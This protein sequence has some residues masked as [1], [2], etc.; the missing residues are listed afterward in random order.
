MVADR[1]LNLDEV[2]R[3]VR[4]RSSE[5]GAHQR[6]QAVGRT[7]EEILETKLRRLARWRK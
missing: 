2:I 4:T 1:V 6:F 5:A 3:I 7:A